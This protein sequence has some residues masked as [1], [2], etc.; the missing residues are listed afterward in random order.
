MERSWPLPAAIAAIG[1]LAMYIAGSLLT[2]GVD[3]RGM[4]ATLG[5]VGAVGCLV[6]LAAAVRLIA[7]TARR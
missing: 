3:D 7:T 6:A 5:M 1:I 2:R 4:L